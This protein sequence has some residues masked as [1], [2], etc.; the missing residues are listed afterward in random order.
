MT[1]IPPGALAPDLALIDT[2]AQEAIADLPAPFRAAALQVR[3][4]VEDFAPEAILAQMDI[5]DPFELTGLYEGIPL[6]EKSSD[7]PPMQP[8]VIWLFRRPILDEWLDRG[9]VTLQDLVTHVL[10][11]ELAH[12]FGWSDDDIARIDPWWE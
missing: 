2:L 8:D 6:T 7:D 3:L 9:D 12:H 10:V 4:R 5:D 11:H 1:Q